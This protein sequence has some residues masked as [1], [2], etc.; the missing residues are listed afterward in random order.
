V[1]LIREIMFLSATFPLTDSLLK[2]VNKAKVAA[3]NALHYAI[4]SKQ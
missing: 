3:K 1:L 4:T 2:P